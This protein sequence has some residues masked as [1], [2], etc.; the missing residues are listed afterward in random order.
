MHWIQGTGGALIDL[1]DTLVT[2]GTHPLP[3]AAA[4]LARLRGKGLPFRICSNTTRRSRAAICYHLAEGE[5][6]LEPEDLV[7][8]ASLARRHIVES[9]KPRAMLLVPSNCLEDFHGVVPDD[10]DPQWVVLGDLGAGFTHA[11]LS[12]A[13]R[14]I[15]AGAGFIALHKNPSWSPDDGGGDVL[16][17]GAYAEALRFATGID[18]VV[19]GKPAAPFY[20]IAI[21]EL[22][23]PPHQVLMI[24]DSMPNDVVGAAAVGC[25]TCLVRR[26]GQAP[27]DLEH[28]RVA[29]DLI[30][31]SVAELVP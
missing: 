4:F 1:D 23:L 21:D 31:E 27:P 24:G 5:F 22:G 2:K 8:P 10:A 7:I 6:D 15:R 18:P 16:D 28:A 30:V 3:G 19:V 25:K 26:A 29:P 9:G 11:R 20:R 13:F 14:A 17:I 12:Q